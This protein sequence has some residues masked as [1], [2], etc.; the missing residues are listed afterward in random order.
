MSPAPG[1]TVS[2]TTEAEFH[3]LSAR[4]NLVP[5]VRELRY[6]TGSP[7]SVFLRLP[8]TSDA[9][10]LESVEGG[11]RWAR[12]SFVGFDPRL[13]I[14]QRGGSAAIRQGRRTAHVSDQPPLDVLRSVLKRYHVARS[15]EVPRFV[16][17]LV[18]Y[19]GWGAVRWFEPRVPARLGADPLF[20]DAEWMLVDRLIAFDRFRHTV[21]LIACVDTERQRS[22]RAAFREGQ[23][24]LDGLEA[25]LNRPVPRRSQPTRAGPLRPT[26]EERGF[27][28]A[29]E[30]SKEYIA[31][32]DCMQV[33]LSRRTEGRFRGDPFELYR[34]IRVSN[35]APYLFFLRFG[36]RAL[37]GASPEVMVRVSDGTVTVRPIAGTRRR[38]ATPE[39]DQQLEAELRTD[40]KELAEHVMLLDLGRNDVGRVSAPGTVRVDEREVI[41]R[42]SHVMHLVSQVSG[43]L[44]EGLDSLDAIASVFPAGTVSGAPKVRAME[45]IDELEPVPRGPYA[46]AVG[47]LGFDG[48]A[49]L[50]IT[51]RGVV[52]S[53]GTMR[54]QAGAGLVHDSRPARE[55]E[56][57]EE[58][59]RGVQF[60]LGLEPKKTIAAR[61]GRRGRR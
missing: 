25:L 58:K 49:D 7:V 50:A 55:F 12:Y 13:T 53:G 27:L 29:V 2:R 46:G 10:L 1:Q 14:E 22:R 18:G 8:R 28:R 52:V 4:G 30:R 31:A 54:L 39:E 17:G 42:Y 37:A 38:G 51:I 11:E 23:R 21:K 48:S 6:D 19:L 40:A 34:S 32:G 3:A 56:E 5:I 33:V 47:Y 41:E 16:G 60:A 44:R 57:T 35:P 43:T 9:F 45:I 61:R 15:P 59:M 36:P 20:P 26:W 24:A